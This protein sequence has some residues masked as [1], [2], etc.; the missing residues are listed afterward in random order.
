VRAEA[1]GSAT[2]VFSGSD[3][4][5]FTGTDKEGLT[6]VPTD[7]DLTQP[8]WAEKKF[9]GGI[10]VLAC[11]LSL[12][13]KGQIRS[14]P[15]W[16]QPAA[17]VVRESGQLHPHASLCGER[18]AL[19]HV[20][21]QLGVVDLKTGRLLGKDFQPVYPCEYK[22]AHKKYDLNAPAVLAALAEYELDPQMVFGGKG[23]Q[24]FA[25]MGRTVYA[26]T[27]VD[28]RGYLYL[29][30]RMHDFFVVEL[31]D[32]GFKVLA[33]NVIDHPVCIYS[34]AEPVLRG[35]RIY[36]R[37]WTHMFCFEKAN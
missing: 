35:N 1:D 34:H 12:D 15:L 10:R 27:A 26:R 11:R 33:K 37:T 25:R 21:G 31:T 5:T 28:A 6:P 16:P 18:I 2:V 22:T 23:D 24:S 19:L 30:N 17:L 14:E 9:V 20:K 29:A 32:D 13:A 36:Y 4:K 3:G 8:A 7:S